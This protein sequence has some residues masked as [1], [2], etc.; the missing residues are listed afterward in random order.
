MSLSELID[1]CLMSEKEMLVCEKEMQVRLGQFW[2]PIDV[3][4]SKETEDILT[5]CNSG[6]I[7]LQEREYR[8]YGSSGN[9]RFAVFIW[10][11]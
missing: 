1:S 4:E 10:T 8:S 3:T 11:F 6:K 5:D 2:Y 9:C 7:W